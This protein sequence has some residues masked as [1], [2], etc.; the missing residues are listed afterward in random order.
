MYFSLEEMKHLR[1]YQL[2]WK[3]TKKTG[4]GDG[5]TARKYERL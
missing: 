1:A 3:V 2:L 4:S 5:G